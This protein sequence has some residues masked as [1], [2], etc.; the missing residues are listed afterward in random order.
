MSDANMPDGAVIPAIY[1]NQQLINAFYFAAETMG[2]DY[3][4]W[5]AAVGIDLDTLAASRDAVYSGPPLEQL[6]GL[7][8]SQH[9]AVQRELLGELFKQV[10][11]V[12]SVNAPDGL[13]L[14]RTPAVDTQPLALL[15][16]TTLLQVLAEQG[17]WLFVIAGNQAGYV[18]AAHV[19]RRLAPQPVDPLPVSPLEPDTTEEILAPPAAEQLSIPD[20][21]DAVTRTVGE[22][23]NHYGGLLKQEA[24]RL[25]IDATMAAA[26]LAAESSGRGYGADGRLL[27][28]FENHLFYDQWGVQHQPEFFSHFAFDGTNRWRDHRWRADPN[29]AWQL[30]HQD[31][32]AIEWQVFQLAHQ[33]DETAALL[34]ISMGM[35]Q[36]M[37]FNY[38]MVG[39]NSPQEMM[40]A[41]QASI[42]HQ[43]RGFFR[44]I[45]ARRLVEAV[46]TSDL[47]TFAA[48]YNGPGQADIYA[49]KLQ[50]YAAALN[51]LRA[52]AAAAVSAPQ[53][54]V[55]TPPVTIPAAPIPAPAA[56]QWLLVG[57]AISNI[58]LALAAA[59]S[60]FRR[61]RKRRRFSWRQI[62]SE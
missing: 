49:A 61:R 37:G 5:L 23:W 47:V 43:I 29:G 12:G 14:R 32:Q 9:A 48:G 4:A 11:W 52:P 59:A 30:G 53:P 28:R 57:L 8:T 2:G 13:N 1:T 33:F 27:I 34:S 21:A 31:D 19:L 62:D 36:I 22:L 41:Y 40:R 25:A 3:T 51:S 35:A 20:E 55:I 44:F 15:S 38:A 16:H 10:R 24:Q 60:A 50:G 42:A 39:F 26:L 7:T 58:L 17:G 46:R 45:E 18:Y 54:P 6:E 56:Q